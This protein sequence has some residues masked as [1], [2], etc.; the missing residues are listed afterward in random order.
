M[1]FD[2]RGRRARVL[3]LVSRS[4]SNVAAEV[5]LPSL[6]NASLPYAFC[7]YAES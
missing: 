5:W 3:V 6:L 2:Y 1:C 4:V 7:R